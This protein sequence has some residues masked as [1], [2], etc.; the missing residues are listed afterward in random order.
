MKSEF[1]HILNNGIEAE[2]QRIHRN[3]FFLCL[4]EFI[5]NLPVYN[6]LKTPIILYK[7]M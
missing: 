6:A 2:T 7:K 4:V 5:I 1:T 3:I